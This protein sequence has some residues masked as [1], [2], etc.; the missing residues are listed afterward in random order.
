[1]ELGNQDARVGESHANQVSGATRRRR[2]RCIGCDA[3]LPICDSMLPP[4]RI[5]T[6]ITAVDDDKGASGPTGR[7]PI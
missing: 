1:M 3:I 5:V 4:A 7:D 6:P 2:Q